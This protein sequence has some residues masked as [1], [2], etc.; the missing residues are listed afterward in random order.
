MSGNI[1]SLWLEK[2]LGPQKQGRP[3]IFSLSDEDLNLN[4]DSLRSDWKL[5]KQRVKYMTDFIR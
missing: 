1:N 5:T 4:L 2:N 3:I